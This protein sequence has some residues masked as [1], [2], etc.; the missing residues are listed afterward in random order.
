MMTAVVSMWFCSAEC[1]LVSCL[2]FKSLHRLRRV[3]FSETVADVFPSCLSPQLKT[4]LDVLE[5]Q[6]AKTSALID[7]FIKGQRF[8]A[9]DSN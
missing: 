3:C 8:T 5:M 6:T 7:H 1:C 4:H 9:A 2:V